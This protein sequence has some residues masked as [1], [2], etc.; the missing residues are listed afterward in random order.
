MPAR[1]ATLADFL[2]SQMLTIDA[3]ADDGWGATLPVK[4]REIDATILFADISAFSARTAELDAAETLAFVNHFIAW[5][6]AEALA[7]RPGIVDKYIGDEVMVVFSKEFGSDDPFLDAVHA[8]RWMGQNDV[9]A[10]APHIGIASGR[11][12][13]G[14]TGTPQGYTASVFGAPVA[15]AARCA[16]APVPA[17]NGTRIS[18]YLTV[19]AGELNGREFAELV[20]TETREGPEGENYERPHGWQLLDPQSVPMKNMGDVEVAQIANTA[21]WVPSESA[22]TRAKTVVRLA[23]QARR[24]WI[25]ECDAQPGVDAAQRPSRNP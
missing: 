11:V 8:A 6:S 18:S 2:S 20:P 5:V 13:V 24:R 4:G 1:Y 16:G 14:Y 12:I 7:D 19:P 15:L 10:F 17:A 21:M 9:Y 3:T 25:P 23:S 22:E